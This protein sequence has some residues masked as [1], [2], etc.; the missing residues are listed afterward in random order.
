M[1]KTYG[2]FMAAWNVS[3]GV[4]VSHLPLLKAGIKHGVFGRLL[5]TPCFILVAHSDPEAVLWG[6]CLLPRLSKSAGFR[7]GG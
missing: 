6:N 5:Y 3:L 4:Y 2:Y 1:V 7:E